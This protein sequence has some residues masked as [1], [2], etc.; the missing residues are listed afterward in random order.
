MHLREYLERQERGA[1]S[2]LAR[3]IGASH[4][5]LGD[6]ITGRRNPSPALASAIERA[7]HGAVTA[8][9]LLAHLVPA[10]YELRR[11]PS[12]ADD[13]NICTRDADCSCDAA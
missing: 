8:G 3:S 12:C 5:T 1:L 13:T 10:G 7:T 4:G 11:L 9:E 6:I 2:Q